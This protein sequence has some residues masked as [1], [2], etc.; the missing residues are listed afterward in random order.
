MNIKKVRVVHPVLCGLLWRQDES[1]EINE[2][3]IKKGRTF[4]HEAPNSLS[5]QQSL[6][7]R[8]I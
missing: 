4:V 5:S 3:K 1:A 2:S 6:F 8:D 7:R